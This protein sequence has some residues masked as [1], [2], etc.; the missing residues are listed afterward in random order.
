AEPQR[1]PSAQLLLLFVEPDERVDRRRS[2]QIERAQRSFQ[3]RHRRRRSRLGWRRFEQSQL[4]PP[5]APSRRER[6]PPRLVELLRLEVR[7][8]LPCS[9]QDGVGE[10]GQL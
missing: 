8:D 10:S 9:P 2:R 5:L 1:R 7:E 3:R 6:G 4:L